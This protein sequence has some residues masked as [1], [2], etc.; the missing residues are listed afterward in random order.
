MDIAMTKILL[1]GCGK[2][3]TA[4]L[5]GW[6]AKLEDPLDFTVIDPMIGA[7]HPCAGHFSAGHFS[8][9]GGRV[10]IMASAE[11]Y[12]GDGLDPP[13]MI[14]LAIKPQMMAE[15]LPELAKIAGRHTVWMSIAAGI[16]VA[17][18]KEYLGGEAAVIRAMPNTPAAIGQGITAMLVDDMADKAMIRLSVQLMGVIGEVVQLDHEDDM[19]AVTAV[20]GSGPAYIF[21]MHE[22]LKAAAI[23]AGLNPNLAAQLTA[24]TMRGATC[25]MDE[26]DESP[27]QLRVNVTSPAGTTEAALKVLM[28]DDGL[29]TMM[30]KAV[31]AARDRSRELGK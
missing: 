19:D 23:A 31:L 26:S 2:M 6:L 18:I 5:T 10:R 7:D 22:A 11:E 3:G 13:N 25:L 30:R 15:A 29:M 1:V 27:S 14:V 21:L 20:S 9:G 24:A 12:H 17:K 28:A 8:A 4:M 16:T